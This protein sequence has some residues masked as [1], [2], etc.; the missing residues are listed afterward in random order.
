MT[1]PP[2]PRLPDGESQT[3]AIEGDQRG[4][5]PELS[6]EALKLIEAEKQPAAA[7]QVAEQL[8][9]PHPEVRKLAKSL[10]AEQF[11]NAQRPGIRSPNVRPRLDVSVYPSS[12]DRALRIMD[13]LLKAFDARGWSVEVD[14]EGKHSTSTLVLDERVFFF[15]DEKTARSDHTPTP[16]E[17]REAKEFTWRAPPKWDFKP[18]GLLRLQIGDASYMGI[19]TLWAGGEKRR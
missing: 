1:R 7:I 5:S 2:L 19:R 6:D 3:I 17:K 4:P 11:G 10:R 12:V 16:E 14:E 9:D 18:S 15:L 8:M 13:T